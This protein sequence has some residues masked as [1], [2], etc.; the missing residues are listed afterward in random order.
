MRAARATDD[1]G[2]AQLEHDLLDVVAG[3]AFLRRDLTPVTGPSS[4]RRAR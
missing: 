3:Q 1:P 4:T 2:A